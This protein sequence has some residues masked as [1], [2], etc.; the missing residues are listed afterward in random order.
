[1]PLG[2]LFFF[3][4]ISL[5]ILR[6]VNETQAYKYIITK[7]LLKPRSRVRDNTVSSANAIVTLS[8]NNP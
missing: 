5:Q 8:L 7:G 3:F 1:M 2:L 6:D 4:L